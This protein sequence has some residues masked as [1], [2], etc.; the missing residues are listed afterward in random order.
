MLYNPPMP[1]VASDVSVV[2]VNWNGKA[3]LESLIPTLMPLGVGEIIVVDN[4]S[5]DG[6]QAWLRKEYPDILL[7]ENE[8]NR[9]FSQ[10]N[11]LA[12]RHAKGSVLAFINN[13]MRVSPAWITEGL[14]GLEQA[15]C[16]GCRILDWEG[17]HIDFNGSS[18]QYLGYAIQKDVGAVL[19]SVSAGERLLFA[20]GG[21]MLIEKSLFLDLEGFDEDFFAVFEDVDLGWRIW[22]SGHEVSFSPESVVFHRG[23]GTFRRE[24]EAKMRYLMH[25]NALLTIAKNYGDELFQKIVPLAV[26]MSIRRAVRCSRVQR[27]SFYIWE[28]ARAGLAAGDAG[29]LA[30]SLDS[31]NHLVATDDFI[32]MLP[33]LL[34]KRRRIQERRCRPDSE[35]IELFGDPLRAIVED[36]DYVE[37]EVEYLRN[38]G[39][40]S[41]FS[42][43]GYERQ[44]G[45][46]S[47]PAALRLSSVRAEVRALQWTG[48]QALMHPPRTPA[49]TSAL[50]KVLQ[51]LRVFGIRKTAGLALK[52]IRHGR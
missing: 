39:L 47:D 48:A 11:N 6:T 26:L 41:V 7:L 20:C 28:A 44:L 50:R 38:L 31:M 17:R 35:I 30:E 18:L 37:T 10:P 40:D 45:Q 9:G 23:H 2:T 8:T 34:E 46:L 16:T 42:L 36:Y 15:P 29:A 22:L 51:S 25:R 21:A 32:R 27:E 49:P 4:G 19:D 43:E 1:R 5:T 52:R 33:S 24:H 12:A 14:K 13:D 3:H